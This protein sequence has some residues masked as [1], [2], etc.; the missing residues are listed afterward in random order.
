MHNLVVA[1]SRN[2]GLRR[3]TASGG[4]ALGYAP[5]TTMEPAVVAAIAAHAPA[6]GVPFRLKVVSKWLVKHGHGA[7][8][9]FSAHYISNAPLTVIPGAAAGTANDELVHLGDLFHR[10]RTETEERIDR[11]LSRGSVAAYEN[12]RQVEF[13]FLPDPQGQSCLLYTSPSPRDS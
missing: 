11:N 3:I 2:S 12:I 10:I 6:G 13:I 7:D 4:G 5:L 1:V 8:A 9:E